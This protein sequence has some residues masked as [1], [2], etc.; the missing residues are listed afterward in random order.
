MELAGGDTTAPYTK[1]SFTLIGGL[2]GGKTYNFRIRARNKWGYGPYSVVVPIAA[3][4]ASDR[5]SAPKVD[6]S[7]TQVRISWLAPFNN[8]ASIN[9]YLIEI[10]QNP[11]DGEDFFQELQN[12]DGSRIDVYSLLSCDIP[13]ATLRA[14]PFNLQYN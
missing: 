14:A 1:T 5:V 4:K 9:Q 7:G 2:Q 8:G 11:L 12:C 6:Y 10:K 3:S 13:M